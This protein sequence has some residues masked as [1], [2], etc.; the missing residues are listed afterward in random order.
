MDSGILV[1]GILVCIG[2]LIYA[3]SGLGRVNSFQKRINEQSE[4][5]IEAVKNTSWSQLRSK[6]SMTKAEIKEKV[7]TEAMW[8]VMNH[9]E[10]GPYSRVFDLDSTRYKIGSMVEFEEYKYE[11]SGKL[12]LYDKYGSVK[13]TAT[14]TCS[15]IWI[16]QDGEAVG[17]GS[18]EVDVDY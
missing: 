12:Y 1:L 8:Y 16:N 11:V 10:N 9:L 15:C 18:T 5:E 13:G 14:F 2:V 6:E 3:I 4:S 7:E 17:L